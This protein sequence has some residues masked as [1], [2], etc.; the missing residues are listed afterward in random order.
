MKEKKKVKKQRQTNKQQ[1]KFFFHFIIENSMQ[2]V[3]GDL[4]KVQVGREYESSGANEV[5][6]LKS[7]IFV[8]KQP[9]QNTS[10]R[11]GKD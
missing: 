6:L 1:R 7:T 9:I 10:Y 4:S 5:K 2:E 11:C 8:S 3:W